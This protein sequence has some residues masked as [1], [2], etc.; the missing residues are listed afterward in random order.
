MH[1]H[2]STAVDSPKPRVAIGS[3]Q[4]NDNLDRLAVQAGT[5]ADE[6]ASL[7]ARRVSSLSGQLDEATAQLTQLTITLKHAQAQG[8]S[9]QWHH[10]ALQRKLA[11]REGDLQ[12]LEA[13]LAAAQLESAGRA[14]RPALSLPCCTLFGVH[15]TPGLVVASLA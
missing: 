6:R 1:Q 7:Q 9:H 8:S 4:T 12:A 2:L 10:Q 14:S 5:Y 11:V 15:A 3:I 13:K